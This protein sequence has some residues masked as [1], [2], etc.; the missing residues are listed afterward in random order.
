LRGLEEEIR[1]FAPTERKVVKVFEWTEKAPGYRFKIHFPGRREQT[2]Q[3]HFGTRYGWFAVIWS[4]NF[5]YR[6]IIK[7]GGV[8]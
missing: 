7:I 5:F 2:L 4:G 1:G 8:L 6:E 3:F